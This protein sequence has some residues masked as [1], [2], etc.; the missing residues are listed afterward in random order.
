MTDLNTGARLAR[1]FATYLSKLAAVYQPIEQ[2]LQPVCRWP[3]SLGVLLFLPFCYVTLDRPIATFMLA[4]AAWFSKL[5]AFQ[6]L[7]KMWL[8]LLLVACTWFVSWLLHRRPHPY[9]E[10]S[11]PSSSKTPPSPRVASKSTDFTIH[12]SAIWIWLVMACFSCSALKMFL[13]RARPVLWFHEHLFGFF[14][15]TLQPTY[16]SFPSGH[17]MTFISVALGLSMLW[18]AYLRAFL[19][20]GFLC[21]FTR[22]LLTYHYVSDVV[23]TTYFSI[24]LLM[25]FATLLRRLAALIP[26]RIL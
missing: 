3:V 24:I 12:L 16:H 25:L 11:L 20:L 5:E 19:G 8:Y 10:A 9:A 22:V 2:A 26:P 21:A 1:C 15:P 4:H 18:P 6:L 23:G 7:G 14:G 13:G 17:T